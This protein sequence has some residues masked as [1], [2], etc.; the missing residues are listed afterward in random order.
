M[1][2]IVKCL[3]CGK[4]IDIDTYYNY[5]HDKIRRRYYHDSCYE[6]YE[7]EAGMRAKIHEKAKEFLGP[8]YVKAKVDR[9][10]VEFV[11]D[12]KKLSGIYGSLVYWY[13]KMGNTSENANGGIG[14]VPHIYQEAS[15]YYARQ[16]ENKARYKTVTDEDVESYINQPEHRVVTRQIKFK[17]PKHIEYVHL[18]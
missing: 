6:E 18:D 17:K 13:D 4:D 11:A 12:G 5:T 9:Q 14:I 3:Y 10:I 1:A 2:H 15:E 7:K 8:S 16:R